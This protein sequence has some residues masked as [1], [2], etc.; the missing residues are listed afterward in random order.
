MYDEQLARYGFVPMDHLAPNWF[1]VASGPIYDNEGREIPGY[2]RVYRED[3]GD[4]FNIF[5]DSYELSDYRKTAE[6]M[7]EAIAKSALR[8]EGMLIGQDMSNNGGALFR[9]YLLP[10]E[11]VEIRGET[12]ALRI[13]CFD[14]YDGSASRSLQSG[15]FVF[16]CA[17]R[18]VV[19]NSALKLAFKHTK[20]NGVRFEQA[21]GQVVK[22]A[23]MATREARRM[24]QWGDINVDVPHAKQL[25]ECLPQQTDALVNSLVTQYATKCPDHTLWGVWNLLTSW[26]THG[27]EG[28]N[29]ARLSI[30]RQRRVAALTQNVAWQDA[31]I[32][33]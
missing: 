7:D 12:V 2:K 16:T 13:I 4:V 10:A 20:G 31:E 11:A 3:S 27:I 22:A 23:E 15:H 5:G 29:R 24:Q 1:D 14:S 6:L 33:F 9:Q 30:D 21:V 26:A 32:Q 25:F 28:G 8:T 19:G 18:S 17:N